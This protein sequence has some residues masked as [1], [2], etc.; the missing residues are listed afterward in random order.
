[1]E[2]SIS[3]EELVVRRRSVCGITVFLNI[4]SVEWW[5]RSCLVI[6]IVSVPAKAALAVWTVTAPPAVSILI[7]VTVPTVITTV[8]ASAPATAP[9]FIVVAVTIAVPS[10]AAGAAASSS[11]TRRTCAAPPHGRRK[12]LGPLV[13]KS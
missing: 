5:G 10:R 8:T 7:L 13:H 12:S 9:I 11:A 3:H 2:G 6:P 1:M 4:F